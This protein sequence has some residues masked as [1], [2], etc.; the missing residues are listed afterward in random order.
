MSFPGPFPIN[1]VRPAS[2]QDLPFRINEKVVAQVLKVTEAQVVLEVNGYPIV[3]KLSSKDQASELLARRSADFIIT[4]ISQDQITLKL[5]NQN[6]K[7]ENAPIQVETNDLAGRLSKAIGLSASNNEVALIRMALLEHLPISRELVNQLL[8]AVNTSGIEAGA[9]IRLAVKLKAAGLPVTPLSLNLVNQFQELHLASSFAELVDGLRNL[10]KQPG[11][12]ALHAQAQNVLARL[13]TMI[14]DLSAGEVEI[15]SCLRELINLIGKPYEKVLS[16]QLSGE[17]GTEKSSFS[18]LNLFNLGKEL[19]QNGLTSAAD[20][21]DRFLDQ[22]RQNQFYN[23]KPEEMPAKGQWSELN[24]IV[25]QP[26]DQ[27]YDSRDARI[28]ISYRHKAK[29][30]VIDPDFSNLILRVDLQPEKEIEV[31]L[32]LY[33]KKINAEITSSDAGVADIFTE[34]MPE[35]CGLLEKLG[36]QVVSARARQTV[37]EEKQGSDAFLV[38]KNSGSRLDIEV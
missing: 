17:N 18:L 33:S 35:F 31:N 15:Q 30:A 3:A 38:D 13:E 23:I 22:V 5:I 24:F 20:G 16:E 34:S 14:P 8:D 21:V 26:V 1:E 19:R 9:G 32:S 11:N 29:P 27:G 37:P 2:M 10:L 7:T 12:I 6:G 28:R 4:H 25:R 36:Y